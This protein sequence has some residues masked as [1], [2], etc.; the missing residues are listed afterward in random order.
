MPKHHIFLIDSDEK[1][2]QMIKDH[3]KNYR[4]YV[5]DIFTDA[6]VC[7]KQLP[8]LKPSVIFLD[9]ELK[10]DPDTVKKDVELMKHLQDLSPNSEVVLFT[11]EERMHLMPDEI[12]KGAHD[13]I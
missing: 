1:H 4:E 8:V 10:H 6:D 11:G 2:A 13:Y 5:I 12:R 9:D 3:L 7:I